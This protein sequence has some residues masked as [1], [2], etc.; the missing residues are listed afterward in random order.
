MKNKEIIGD[1]EIS[2][3]IWSSG[4]IRFFALYW[5]NVSYLPNSERMYSIMHKRIQRLNKMSN[6]CF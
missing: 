3:E 4:E 6:F 2:S 5:M 1:L